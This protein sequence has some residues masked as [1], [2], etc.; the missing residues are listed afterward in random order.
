MEPAV[1]PIQIREALARHL[2]QTLTPELAAA[3]YVSALGQEDCS[4]HP[5]TFGCLERDGYLIRVERLSEILPEL[6]GLHV[7]HWQ[8]TEKHRHGLPLNPDYDYMKFRERLGQ[9]VQFTARRDGA[10]CGHLRMYLGVSTHSGTLF[11]EEDTLYVL[12]EHRGGWLGLHLL[13]FAEQA[14]RKV[15]VRELR[16]DSKLINHA[17]VL[18]RRMRYTPVATR[19]VKILPEI[20]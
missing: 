15:G 13:R 4:F 2:G 9:L 12:P 19:F 11:A 3:I 10:L 5:D 20:L 18:M 17:D 1:H 6:H 7:A 14:L 8:E 16:G